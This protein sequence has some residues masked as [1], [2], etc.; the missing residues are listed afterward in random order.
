M[1]KQ[2]W[3]EQTSLR[4]TIAQKDEVIN[5]LYVQLS[6]QQEINN[7][8]NLHPDL[9]FSPLFSSS[10]AFNKTASM[11]AGLRGSEDSSTTSLGTVN[12]I[13]NPHMVHNARE[14]QAIADR[15]FNI[16][17]R[18]G[19]GRISRDE[20]RKWIID[21]HNLLTEH[22]QVKAVL[23]TEIRNLRKAMSGNSNK[24][25][26][27]L[28]RVEEAQ[29]KQEEE[30][31]K[32]H[33]ERDQLKAELNNLLMKFQELETE[34][35]MAEN[36][37]EDRYNALMA[38]L[39]PGSRV[40]NRDK[41]V[42]EKE[43]VGSVSHPYGYS[44][45]QDRAMEISFAS[46]AMSGG[47]STAMRSQSVAMDRDSPLDLLKLA[48]API[49]SANIYASSLEEKVQS[50][51]MS[52]NQAAEF[53]PVV[54]TRS[55][56]PL[57]WQSPE[58]QPIPHRQRDPLTLGDLAA[59][60]SEPHELSPMA[61]KA[62]TLGRHDDL[63]SP[64]DPFPLVKGRPSAPARHQAVALPRKHTSTFGEQPT[65]DPY[66]QHALNNPAVTQMYWMSRSLPA[67]GTGD[68]V[69]HP[70]RAALKNEIVAKQWTPIPGA[71]PYTMIKPF[72]PKTKKSKVNVIG[73]GDR[74]SSPVPGGDQ[75]NDTPGRSSSPSRTFSPH[76]FMQTT[77]SWAKKAT[78][79]AGPKD[80]VAGGVVNWR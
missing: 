3:E 16:A 48:A 17:D 11:V 66:M 52:N 60:I 42:K 39:G 37:W 54:P 34:K 30:L 61:E 28:K 35:Q 2:L 75:N 6:E 46:P 62:H 79:K 36:D 32:V 25:Y 5:H 33:I 65:H 69:N 13:N 73:G 51:V 49:T 72:K 71:S 20:W 44:I 4:Q 58:H 29:R 67:A 76:R 15:E 78:E 50:P 27:D 64:D 47:E 56:T 1:I 70:L 26:E 74:Y 38:S 43:R 63:L 8:R 59:S 68:V 53:V 41:D 12:P 24:I 21:K 7:S 40:N 22:N 23:T 31:V 14:L 80:T 19:D 57:Q 10:I 18:D 55:S 45:E 77:D 9:A